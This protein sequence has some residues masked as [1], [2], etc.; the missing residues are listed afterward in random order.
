MKINP[1][2]DNYF[3]A[4]IYF[5]WGVVYNSKTDSRIHSSKSTRYH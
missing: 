2:Y 5:I 4:F 1:L 3:M